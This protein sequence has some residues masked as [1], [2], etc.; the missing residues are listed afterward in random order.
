MV[1][2]SADGDRG[3]GPHR[4]DRVRR[5][6]GVP[7]A[8]GIAHATHEWEAPGGGGAVAAVQLAKFAGSA[9]FF[10]AIGDDEIG[11]RTRREL[12]PM[13][14][15]VRAAA[16][17]DTRSRRA[18]TLID[19]AGERTIITLGDRLDPCDGR[20]VGVGR[21][22]HDRRGLRHRRRP[23]SAGP[24][25]Q[26][27]VHGGDEPDPPR[28]LATGVDPDVLVGSARDPSEADRTDRLPWRPRMV[29]R[30]EG[31][32]GARSR[33]PTASRTEGRPPRSR[34]EA[35]PTVLAIRSPR[36][37]RSRWDRAVRRPT[38]W[39]SP[40]DVGPRR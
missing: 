1:G 28:A 40:H 6:D 13:G 2:D 33:P 39:G 11:A 25:S 20:P 3:R 34:R 31:V 15:E 17:N 26:G 24:R 32:R 7:P 29:V 12:A 38:P 27:L 16:R 30:T 36:A 21:P 37:S 5:V 14:V 19:P 23:R 18:L 8:G 35:T 22:R 10:T 4:M 9:T